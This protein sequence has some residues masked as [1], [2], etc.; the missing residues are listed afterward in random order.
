MDMYTLL[1]G[2]NETADSIIDID[3]GNQKEAL[4]AI[5]LL[6][7]LRHDCLHKMIAF[8]IGAYHLMIERPMSFYLDCPDHIGRLTPDMFLIMDNN[9]NI[10]K[11]L[12]NAK[13]AIIVDISISSTSNEQA[14]IKIAKY[15]QIRTLVRDV[16]NIECDIF[17]LNVASNLAD[18]ERKIHDFEGFIGKKLIEF[19]MYEAKHIFQR[20]MSDIIS[21]RELI[22]DEQLVK[23][24]F[25]MEFGT[26][27]VSLLEMEIDFTGR[28]NNMFSK[29]VKDKLR[30][31]S[32]QAQL[33]D[34]MN[35]MESDSY[36]DKQDMTQRKDEELDIICKDLNILLSDETII[37]HFKEKATTSEKVSDAFKKMKQENLLFSTGKIKPTHHIVTPLLENDDIELETAYN[38]LPRDQFNELQLEQKQI[39]NLLALSESTEHDNNA[40]S[41]V[42]AVWESVKTSLTGKHSSLNT[43]LFNKGLYID[44]EKDAEYRD[45]YNKYKSEVHETRTR[46]KS[47]LDFMRDNLKVEVPT[48][49]ETKFIKQKMIR[50]NKDE[51]ES[52]VN[53]FWEKGHSGYK[54][55]KKFN[56][57]P[58]DT[59]D[60]ELHNDFD[61]FIDLLNE[62]LS[63]KKTK[64]ALKGGIFS[65]FYKKWNSVDAPTFQDLKNRM[66]DSFNIILDEIFETKA[67]SYLLNQMLFAEQLM[68]FQQF[69]LATNSLSMFTC[70]MKN[71]IVLLNNSYHDSGK[72][73]GK[74]F[75][76]FGFID[77]LRWA[78]KVYGTMSVQEVYGFG[79]KIYA[80]ATGWRRIETYK[81]TFLRDQYFS[82]MSTAVNGLLRSQDKIERDRT[83][84]KRPYVD[85]LVRHHFTL[86]VAVTL[87][88]NQRVAEMLADMRYAIMASFA[89][90]S[91]IERLCIDK[92]GPPYN[93]ILEV[94]IASRVDN[95]RKLVTDYLE[96]DVQNI[97]FKQP[98]FHR[99][100]RT[101]ES[102]GGHF[103]L[104]SIWDDVILTD[105][106]DLLDD[107]FLYVHTLKEPSNIHHE[108]IKAVNTI[109]EYQELYDKM[110]DSRKKGEY[111]H[112]GELKEMLLDSS[113]PIGHSK[114]ITSNSVYQTMQTLQ[115]TD[116]KSRFTKIFNEPIANITS[117]KAAI[118][119]YDREL[120][121]STPKMK[122][123]KARLQSL[124]KSLYMKEYSRH[125]NTPTEEYK[126]KML[127]T[128]ISKESALPN[129]NRSKVHDCIL[130]IIENNNYIKTVFDLAEWNVNENNSKT[131][132]D[133]CIK[134]QYGAKR[135]FYVINV[136]SKACARVL[137]NMFNEICKM[138][139]NEM[140]S[141]PGD[142]K[143]LYMQDFLNSALS[144]KQSNERIFFV[145]G[146]CTKWS[147]A[148]TME[149]FM[150]L[151]YGLNEF[152]P[153]HCI[154]YML[155]VVNM[156]GNKDITIPISLLQNT[157]FTTDDKTKYLKSHVAVLESDQNFLQGMFNYMSSFKAVCCSNM[158]RI[159][160]KK[161]R[162]DSKL[163]F[164][165]MEH[166][167]DYS[168]IITTSSIE[169]LVEF[170]CLHRILMKCHGFNDSVKKTNTQQFLME[171]ISLL[172]FNG[173]MTY[174]HIKK[175][176]ECGLNLGCTGYRDDM[177][178]VLSRVGEAVRVGSN[179][180]A[181][182]FMQ[183][184][185]IANLYRAYSLVPGQRNSFSDLQTLINIPIEMFGIPDTFP[186][187]SFLC[188]GTINNYRIYKY[189]DPYKKILFTIEGETFEVNIHELLHKLVR[190]ERAEDELNSVM[191][192]EDFT[193]GIRLFHPSYSFDLENKLIKKI[194]SK[195]KTSFEEA[196]QF[197]EHHKSYNFIKPSSR[198]LLL[199]WM[200][201]IYFKSN[202]AMA[203]SRNSRSQITLR[204]STFT[205]KKC[206]LLTKNKNTVTEPLTVKHYM[207]LFLSGGLPIESTKV[208]KTMQIG[209]ND[210]EKAIMNNDS[211]VSMIYSF[212]ENS[213]C[214]MGGRHDMY[215]VASLSPQKISWLTV[216][217]PVNSLLQ[218]IFNYEDFRT[219]LRKYKSVASLEADKK[220]IEKYYNCILGSST[221]LHTIKSVY[222]DIIQSQKTRNLCMSY[223]SECSSIE[224]YIKY[225]IE[226]GTLYHKKLEIYSSGI[227]EAVNPHDLSVYY[228]KLRTYARNPLRVLIDDACLLYCLMKHCYLKDDASTKHALMQLHIGSL[229]Y[230]SDVSDLTFRRLIEDFDIDALNQIGF[231][232]NEQKIH[233][234]LK[235]FLT[236]DIEPLTILSNDNT[237][238]KYQYVDPPYQF[239]DIFSECVIYEYRGHYFKAYRH[240]TTKTIIVQVENVSKKHLTDAWLI[241]LRLLCN[242]TE[243]EFNANISQL[244]LK[245]FSQS[246]RDRTFTRVC[247]DSRLRDFLNFINTE[248]VFEYNYATNRSKFEHWR[249]DSCSG[250]NITFVQTQNHEIISAGKTEQYNKSIRISWESNSVFM[251]FKKIFTLPMLSCTQSNITESN[252]DLD[253]NGIDINWWL[254]ASRMQSLFHNDKIHLNRNDFNAFGKYLI[255]EEG[256][257]IQLRSKRNIQTLKNFPTHLPDMSL[258]EIQRKLENRIKTM[259]FNDDMPPPNRFLEDKKEKTFDVG[260]IASNIV[261][262][263]RLLFMDIDEIGDELDLDINFMK[264]MHL[265][266]AIPIKP[267]QVVTSEDQFI[268]ETESSNED[269]YNA[270]D[271]FSADF[272]RNMTAKS[273]M[274]CETIVPQHDENLP[275][276]RESVSNITGTQS[277]HDDISDYDEEY[278][279]N[280][281]M[282]SDFLRSMVRMGKMKATEETIEDSYK[283]P[284]EEEFMD[285]AQMRSMFDN[286]EHQKM[287]LEHSSTE[288]GADLSLDF[289][290]N[291]F[292]KTVE[293]DTRITDD[294]SS[295]FVMPKFDM[296]RIKI[297]IHDTSSEDGTTKSEDNTKQLEEDTLGGLKEDDMRRLIPKISFAGFK[298][299]EL[300]MESDEDD[301]FEGRLVRDSEPSGSSQSSKSEANEAYLTKNEYRSVRPLMEGKMMEFMKAT[302]HSMKIFKEIGD[303]TYFIVNK[304]IIT[305]DNIMTYSTK[306]KLGLLYQLNQI[307][308]LSHHISDLELME[309]VTMST[310]IIE[311]FLGRNEWTIEKDYVLGFDKD[312]NFE[313][314][315]KYKDDF[316]DIMKEKAIKKGAISR[317][318]DGESFLYI[319]LAKSRKEKMLE[320]FAENSSL[321]E[322]VSLKIIH[323]CH[324][325]L[326]IDPNE[327]AGFILQLLDEL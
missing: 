66:V 273:K 118:P 167:D 55:E 179:L 54:K 96:N 140:I 182:Y 137:E 57:K 72:D 103:E 104:P 81:C 232:K 141:I 161:I 120:V 237:V 264:T 164:E 146:D 2:F 84:T 300:E 318:V 107:M 93:N 124:E 100:R 92:F 297:T 316:D 262:D 113:N 153:K 8:G 178:A 9:R 37:S 218:Y 315:I 46:M 208:Y 270:S 121:D 127:K 222:T 268:K 256:N 245:E 32:L 65:E 150:S 79:R 33:T 52:E 211:T 95:L 155:M 6:Y 98:V 23:K 241:A 219:D 281:D 284:E 35:K 308:H 63:L 76:V 291:M 206:L 228:K 109:L 34:I 5:S 45:K 129:K 267:S 116:W 289:M 10:I 240:K 4:E 319:P 244:T 40:F 302:P 258:N 78:S 176:K 174:P 298:H 287:R 203:Y 231:T 169:E 314:Y 171:F 310:H 97:F 38:I 125:K 7:K 227:T 99:N 214:L 175:L 88:S 80:F 134:A 250:K 90:F 111:S 151:I 212:I 128:N 327:R 186:L 215:T 139:P 165:H 86:K 163:R 225:Q 108:N 173:H 64:T 278:D 24:H 142:K 191:L 41:F 67:Y 18:L 59:C 259:H 230:E 17:I 74:A 136:G 131:L 114:M 159:V 282:S 283:D 216:N 207:K 85:R 200:R 246:T 269:D 306:D 202:F 29:S 101:D 30:N 77:D 19:D 187:T 156:W 50:I 60:F 15:D 12:E 44:A 304:N 71:V 312:A 229:K 49:K 321:D 184:V 285:S 13:S 239:R 105:L 31:K 25:E 56:D 61:S 233:S 226:F 135:E 20:I 326:F 238:Y 248:T 217:N 143:M 276:N 43:S 39:C 102:I 58:R 193:E 194:R 290:K 83:G 160:W 303:P 138:L 168:L 189:T 1:Q 251:G 53:A 177:D 28:I 236:G 261:S 323:D 132:A 249:N 185:H 309:S 243:T 122:A 279:P 22:S 16:A 224:D 311:S 106:Q 26:H 145:N 82:I 152:I 188:K 133:I 48:N 220:V 286:I 235:A 223:K 149:C 42:K 75:M 91:E 296:S 266:E 183:R 27:E 154:Q 242:M 213:R 130:D 119:E 157:F 11:T 272:L 313:I 210:V 288:Q 260:K 322:A 21:L 94:W 147:A 166:S 181:A 307:M 199:Q 277:E 255:Q 280:N 62:P 252:I 162:P 265:K 117:T 294:E 204:L 115:G 89:E 209:G 320:R 196:T 295:Q 14:E 172:S 51:L 192:N 170:R 271:D 190:L 325:R 68:H 201:S 144:K 305:K 126:S 221:P 180:T 123:T 195:V 205:S 274:S 275:E 293:S 299:M 69:S 253:L 3:E 324:R 36:I 263:E 73:V 301:D 47:M 112:L 70:G 254:K 198:D 247:E 257:M 292:K 87:C 234:F 158:T 148:E 110:P 317:N 197:W